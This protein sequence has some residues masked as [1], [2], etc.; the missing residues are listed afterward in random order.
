MENRWNARLIT[1]LIMLALAFIGIV[2]FSIH[3]RAYWVYTQVMAF[4]Y[5]ILSLWLYWY[6]GRGESTPK[7]S[8]FLR[9][10]I[11]WLGLWLSIFLIALFVNVGMF[12]ATQ[13]GLATFVLTALT[14]FLAGI[15]TDIIFI[16]IGVTLA[17]LIVAATYIQSYLPIWMIPVIVIAAGIVYFL[18]KKNNK[19][20]TKS[21][22]D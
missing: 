21:E 7:H 16:L 1:A 4:L 3:S 15:H 11:H 5:A 6:I 18:T 8:T 20:T 13:A 12:N 19:G 2:I 17:I 14:L 22:S 9:Q 10:A